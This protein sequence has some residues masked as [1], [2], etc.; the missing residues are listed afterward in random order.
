M[1]QVCVAVH[2]RSICCN[3]T[4]L[5]RPAQIATL[6]E[7]NVSTPMPMAVSYRPRATARSTRTNTLRIQIVPEGILSRLRI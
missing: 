1:E 3:A 7:S 6:R 4:P 2:A 5:Q